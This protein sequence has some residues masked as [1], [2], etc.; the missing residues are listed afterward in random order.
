MINKITKYIVLFI[1]LVIVITTASLTFSADLRRYIFFRVIVVHDFY[2]LKSLVKYVEGGRRHVKDFS[3]A[4]DKLL[5]YI[6]ISKLLS[7]GKSGMWNG[8][9]NAVDYVTLRATTQKEFNQ[10][11]KVFLSLV[12]L[13]PNLYKARIWLARAISD[14]DYKGSLAHIEKAIEILPAGEDAYRE[15]IRILQDKNDTKLA[16]KFCDKYLKAQLGGYMPLDGGNFFGASGIR[17]MAVEFIPENKDPAFYPN[18]GIQL[19]KFQNYE[20]I[21]SYPL[22]MNG[23]NVYLSSLPGIRVYIKEIA[24]YLSGEMLVIPIQNFTITSKFAYI[25]EDNDNNLSFIMVNG[26]NEVL[27]FR[28][29]KTFKSVDKITIGMNFTKMKLVNNLLCEDAKE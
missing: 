1:M 7:D 19:N 13:D 3:A 22:T 24:I 21:P 11:E 16:Q 8:I 20:F 26:K 15:A 23:I 28:H 27:R 29:E 25:E 5:K 18:S 12:E 17:K 14:T 9:Y 10:L 6:E 2:Q 4:S